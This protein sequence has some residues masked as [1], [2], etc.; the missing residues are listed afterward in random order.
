M[1][2][3]TEEGEVRAG[4]VGAGRAGVSNLAASLQ[5]WWFTRTVQMSVVSITV[6]HGVDTASILMTPLQ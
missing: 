6:T 5:T 2:V 4:V 3:R 1:L